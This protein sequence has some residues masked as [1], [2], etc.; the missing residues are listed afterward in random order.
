MPRLKRNGP[1]SFQRAKNQGIDVFF[2]L[3]LREID[4]ALTLGPLA[5]REGR[6]TIAEGLQAHTVPENEATQRQE[7][8]QA[9]GGGTADDT[10]QEEAPEDRQ[11]RLPTAWCEILLRRSKV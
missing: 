11:R 4:F 1:R 5:S 9:S 6:S 8:C 2:K 7:E 10:K 3:Y